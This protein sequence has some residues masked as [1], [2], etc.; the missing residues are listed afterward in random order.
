MTTS[1]RLVPLDVGELRKGMYVGEPDR[2]WT[3]LPFILQGFVIEDDETLAILR[4]YCARVYVDPD[5]CADSADE[6]GL[7]VAAGAPAQ[8]QGPGDR[9]D[10]QRP[11]ARGSS[12]QRRREAID[13]E[14][15]YPD[16]E[17]L[18]SELDSA[19]AARVTAR[20]FLDETFRGLQQGVSIDIGSAQSTITELLERLTE[21]P[22]A[23][24]WLT[25]LNDHDDFTPTHSI[26]VSVL[27]LSFCLRAQLDERKLE[28]IGLGTL[29]HDVGKTKLPHEL[30]NRPGPLTPD[31]WE[32]VKRHPQD[33]VHILGDS[34]HVP[35]GA[36]NI[37]GMH[38]E[39][40]NGQGYPK[41]LTQKDLPNYVMATALANRY[42]ALTSPR[43]YRRADQPD[44]VLQSFYNNADALFGSRAVE[45]FIRC[46]GIYPVGSLVELDNGAL[47][48]VVSSRPNTRLRPTVQ[49]VQTPD[50]DRYAK[51]VLLNLAAE[52]ERRSSKGDGVPARRVRRVRSPAETGIDPGA[53][54]AESFGIAIA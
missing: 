18:R 1:G 49:L 7:P 11:G 29:L 8:R 37:V 51:V 47:G 54:V 12:G 24:L 33:G 14:R 6:D 40:R 45:A 52:A 32:Q 34:G 4:R 3:D 23:S 41:G 43:P 28:V 35:R 10:K 19:S 48:V 31:E 36:L 17:G 5:R 9:E 39:R 22:T 2:P 50:G 46:V 30:L 16:P 15:R 53:V 25:S 42:H 26:N 21:N 44:R 27:V 38:H 13:T 20:R